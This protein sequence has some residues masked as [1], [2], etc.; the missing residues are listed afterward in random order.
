MPA[1]GLG[2]REGPA[3]FTGQRPVERLEEVGLL[4]QVLEQQVRQLH[5]HPCP[6]HDPQGAQIL[7][8][9]EE[10]R[11]NWRGLVVSA[12]APNFCVGFNIMLILLSALVRR[13][14]RLATARDA[15]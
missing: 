2:V 3:A 8:T 13:S 15:A 9:A 7:T 10:V 4:L 11:Q 14:A 6:D 12:S 1:C 5:R